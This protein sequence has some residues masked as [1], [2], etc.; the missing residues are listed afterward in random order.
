MMDGDKGGP[1]FPVEA[2]VGTRTHNGMSLRDWFAGQVLVGV[3]PPAEGERD[4][5]D[6]EE[7]M[8][9]ITGYAYQWA[10]AMLAA[11]EVTE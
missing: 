3:L 1:A 4:A 11:R 7:F 9:R 6:D 10:D 2:R 5:E 8:R